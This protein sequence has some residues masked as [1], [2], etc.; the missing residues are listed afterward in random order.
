MHAQVVAVAQL[1]ESQIVILVVVGSSPI[2][3]PKLFLS[4]FKSVA[5]PLPRLTCPH[6]GSDDADAATGGLANRV[7]ASRLI[8]NQ[9]PAQR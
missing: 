7:L 4:A 2:S 6:G 3:H 9:S 1:V 8:H 5:G